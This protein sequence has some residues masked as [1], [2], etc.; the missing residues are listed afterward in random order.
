MNAAVAETPQDDAAN[1]RGNGRAPMSFPSAIL[2][3]EG[4]FPCKLE[5]LSLGGARITTDRKL[6]QGR[7]LWLKLDKLEVFGVVSWARNGEYGIEFEERLPKVVVMQMQGY[8][9]DLDEY[10]AAQGRLAA[11]DWVVGDPQ[12]TKT[13]LMRLLDVV[14]P[15]SREAF[16]TCIQCD[17]GEPCA[18]HCG[19]KQYREY[20]RTQ[21]L[22]TAFFLGLA[23]VLGAIIGIGSE[24]IG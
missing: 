3:S 14:S 18:A 15:K 24:L 19:H 1:R 13:R 6:E 9:V 20:R 21:G 10:E 2:L 23:A 11:K 12:P 16:A 8:S 22:K 7:T 17:L 5:D 4:K